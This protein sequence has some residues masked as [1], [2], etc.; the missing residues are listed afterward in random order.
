MITEYFDPLSISE[1]IDSNEHLRKEI[2]ESCGAEPG[3]TVAPILK[4]LYENAALYASKKTR[5]AIRH[6]LVVKKFACC[7]Y[8]LVGKSGYELLVG[9]L[10][11]ALPSLNPAR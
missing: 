9:N 7:L 1:V 10:G 8:C 4:R 5:N 3:S 6:D 11:T 2:N